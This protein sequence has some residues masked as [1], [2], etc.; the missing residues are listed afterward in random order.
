MLV[1][2]LYYD[3]SNDTCDSSTPS[4]FANGLLIYLYFLFLKSNCEIGVIITGLIKWAYG[5]KLSFIS[6]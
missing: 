3:D 5:K 6:R 4:Q 1:L 2:I